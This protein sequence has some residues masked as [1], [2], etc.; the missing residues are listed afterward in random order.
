MLSD[1]AIDE[2][3]EQIARALPLPPPEDQ[4]TWILSSAAELPPEDEA[5][6]ERAL[7][8]RWDLDSGDP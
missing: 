1:V 7:A 6:V 8:R 2:I 5:R 4:S 3:A